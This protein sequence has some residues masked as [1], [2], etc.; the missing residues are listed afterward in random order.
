MSK[1]IHNRMAIIIN[2]SNSVLLILR[3]KL[4]FLTF[5]IYHP[6]K[7]ALPTLYPAS[8]V[9]P[10]VTPVPIKNPTPT[11]TLVPPLGTATANSMEAMTHTRIVA[12]STNIEFMHCVIC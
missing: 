8:A 1:T 11:I 7:Q 10:I 4:F 5:F 9:R 2:F 3:S 6:P 12:A